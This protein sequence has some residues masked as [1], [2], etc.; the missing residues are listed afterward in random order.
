MAQTAGWR[1]MDTVSHYN[2]NAPGL[3]TSKAL[4]RRLADTA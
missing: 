4:N 1:S 3:H 2:K